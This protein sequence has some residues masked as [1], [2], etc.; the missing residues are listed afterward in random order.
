MAAWKNLQLE[1]DILQNYDE[2]DIQC[3]MACLQIL[4]SQL[5]VVV[6][7]ARSKRL[8]SISDS[9]QYQIVHSDTVKQRFGMPSRL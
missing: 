5:F 2:N 3:Y 4:T 1:I 7:M 8:V 9:L 6:Y